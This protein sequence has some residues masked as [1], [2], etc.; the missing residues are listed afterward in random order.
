MLKKT[1]INIIKVYLEQ[2][3]ILKLADLNNAIIN[4]YSTEKSLEGYKNVLSA[5]YDF[6]KFVDEL[7]DD[8]V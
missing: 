1:T 6:E 4:N 8:N 5:L 3:K 7:D 2:E